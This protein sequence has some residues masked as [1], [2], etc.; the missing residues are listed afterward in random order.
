MMLCVIAIA[1]V[2]IIY[3]TVLQVTD[4]IKENYEKQLD[5]AFANGY[6]WGKLAERSNVIH[7]D[8]VVIDE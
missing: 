7:V 5:E 3:L 2:V 1:T 6:E 4:L 8:A